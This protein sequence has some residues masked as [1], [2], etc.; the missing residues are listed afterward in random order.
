MPLKCDWCDEVIDADY[1]D[2][3]PYLCDDCR[4]IYDRFG[5]KPV[6]A[7][8]HEEISIFDYEE[9][10]VNGYG[11]PLCSACYD[12]YVNA[13]LDLPDDIDINVTRPD[14][15]NLDYNPQLIDWEDLKDRIT[16]FL[17]RPEVKELSTKRKTARLLGVLCNSN[18]SDASSYDSVIDFCSD[19]LKN[20][21]DI[22]ALV[23]RLDSLNINTP[24]SKAPRNIRFTKL[25]VDP[26]VK[27]YVEIEMGWA[28]Y[29]DFFMQT[30]VLSVDVLPKVQRKVE[31]LLAIL[32]ELA[33][34]AGYTEEEL[35]HVAI[36]YDSLGTYLESNMAGVQVGTNIYYGYYAIHSGEYLA[37]VI[38]HEFQHVL[39]NIWKNEK[40]IPALRYRIA[41]QYFK[42][43]L[44]CGKTNQLCIYEQF[45]QYFTNVLERNAI[46]AEGQISEQSG[47]CDSS[48]ECLVKKNGYEFM[49][50]LMEAFNGYKRHN[51]ESRLFIDL[52]AQQVPE[53]ALIPVD[54]NW[55]EIL[56]PGKD[57][58]KGYLESEEDWYFVTVESIN[59]Y[60]Y[61]VPTERFI[62][63]L[64]E[65]VP[66]I[67]LESFYQTI[68]EYLSP[69]ASVSSRPTYS[70]M[71]EMI[72]DS[73]NFHS[74][75]LKRRKVSKKDKP[76]TSL[77]MNA[78]TFVFCYAYGEL[79][80]IYNSLTDEVKK[81]GFGS[82]LDDLIDSIDELE[83]SMELAAELEDLCGELEDL[84]SEA[85]EMQEE[86]SELGIE[87]EHLFEEFDSIYDGVEERIENLA[88]DTVETFHDRVEDDDSP[89]DIP[90]I[91][92]DTIDEYIDKKK[93]IEQETEEEL[94]EIVYDIEEIESMIESL[95]DDLE[96]LSDDIE[97]LVNTIEDKF[98]ELKEYEELA[99][100]LDDVQD[101][102]EKL[103]ED[104]NIELSFECRVMVRVVNSDG[105]PV[106]GIPVT[107]IDPKSEKEFLLGFTDN[108]GYLDAGVD[109]EQYYG[110]TVIANGKTLSYPSVNGT[111]YESKEDVNQYFVVRMEDN[112]PIFVIES[113]FVLGD[114]K[115]TSSGLSEQD[116]TL[117]VVIRGAKT[118]AGELPEAVGNPPSK[119]VSWKEYYA[120]WL[121]RKEIMED[122]KRISN[123]VL[124]DMNEENADYYGAYLIP[125]SSFGELPRT[126]G[127]VLFSPLYQYINGTPVIQ[128][129]DSKAFSHRT[130]SNPVPY[131]SKAFD[132]GKVAPGRYELVVIMPIAE[133]SYH[134]SEITI[135]SGEN[136]VVSAEQWNN[137]GDP[138][139]RFVDGNTKF[140]YKTVELDT[141]MF[142]LEGLASGNISDERYGTAF[143][144]AVDAKG[145]ALWSAVDRSKYGVFKVPAYFGWRDSG[146]VTGSEGD[147][148]E[149]C[150]GQIYLFL[151]RKPSEIT[152]YPVTYLCMYYEFRD[153]WHKFFGRRFRGIMPGRIYCDTVAKSGTSQKTYVA[154]WEQFHDDDGN[155]HYKTYNKP[156]SFELHWPIEYYFEECFDDEI[157]LVD[158]VPEYAN[159]RMVNYLSQKKMLKK[160]ASYV[161]EYTKRIDDI[162][163]VTPYNL[164]PSSF[165]AEPVSITDT[166]WRIIGVHPELTGI[167]RMNGYVEDENGIKTKKIINVKPTI[168]KDNEGVAIR[169]IVG[170]DAKVEKP[171]WDIDVPITSTEERYSI[172]RRS[173]KIHRPGCGCCG[174]MS[175]DNTIPVRSSHKKAPK[176]LKENLLLLGYTTCKR[177]KP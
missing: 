3:E 71:I 16:D 31:G 58:V 49:H 147:H 83:E 103:D 37:K 155:V 27:T 158:A 54:F 102:I 101:T 114:A 122:G 18:G 164:I 5:G 138:T 41:E 75:S 163:P 50:V 10:Q 8:C 11:S 161:F 151:S 40:S 139:S 141:V 56:N 74:I 55:N 79:L 81:A 85:E 28:S 115:Q 9:D 97:N 95:M 24:Y 106:Y 109:T 126:N 98:E 142:N 172:N 121:S 62:K 30:T 111:L 133:Y 159:G 169:F 157:H 45:I 82:N 70:E 6:C 96:G 53:L 65:A 143:A 149:V 21:T 130:D 34:E 167:A 124:Q 123:P 136:K 125:L 26:R 42:Y 7:K 36:N 160:G 35:E 25:L 137:A 33:K 93:E 89:T 17:N 128:L 170:S 152:I 44:E 77:P 69:D 148:I 78:D 154:F 117:S 91:I 145:K 2:E 110:W 135:G 162:N 105:N 156:V 48:K 175:K 94:Q 72:Y 131:I 73:K 67:S 140:R 57:D 64:T 168:H 4:A 76:C 174:L 52:L 129:N 38:A 29:E 127:E 118:A 13:E 59:G 104:S 144:L 46:Q 87:Y 176:S 63:E 132:F 166:L 88:H 12:E 14:E 116:S 90:S 43:N 177:C 22:E 84:C 47:K 61:V 134:F 120:Y 60:R 20:S 107:A 19:N 80:K 86:L 173:D 165:A 1:C 119:S 32:K 113:E 153:E 23:A 100:Q 51:K 15:K 66:G 39:D 146:L 99:E 171:I 108:D 150:M 68:W 92:G 112:E